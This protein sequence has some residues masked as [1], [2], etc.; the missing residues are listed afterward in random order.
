MCVACASHVSMWL[1]GMAR[2]HSMVIVSPIL[3]RDDAHGATIWNTAVVINSD[4]SVLGK[5]ALRCLDAQRCA[6]RN[7]YM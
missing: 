2:A 3:E 6:L 1:C 4:G 5:Q 7:Y